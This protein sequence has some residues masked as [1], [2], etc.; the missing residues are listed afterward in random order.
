MSLSVVIITYNE[1]Q[2]IRACL[3]S[4]QFANEVIVL[5][6]GSTD[7]TTKIAKEYGANVVS[8][9]WP[10]DG[11]QR[12]RGIKLA[13]SNWVLILDADERVTDELRTSIQNIDNSCDGYDVRFQSYYLG[14]AIR[15][16][17]WRGEKHIRL[18]KRAKGRYSECE[19]SGAQGAH[20]R[21]IVNGKVGK[22]K[23]VI[24]HH[25][26]PNLDKMLTKLNAYSSGSA[27]LKVH[28][29][30]KGGLIKALVHAY[31]C[32]LR[33]YIIRRGFLDGKEG[34]ILAVSNAQG[35]FYRYLK[36]LYKGQENAAS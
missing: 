23:G 22:I 20:C 8:T 33:G 18:F 15:H 31:W 29:G 5:D 25:P 4:V 28:R 6:S 14:R 12:N 10:G 34:F 36:M 11:P 30:Q 21:P 17:D 1:E 9:D 35:T 19:V 13:K 16:G 7:N 32:F 26:F 3:E 27:A 2:N 24:E